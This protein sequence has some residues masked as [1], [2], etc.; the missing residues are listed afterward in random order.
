MTKQIIIL[1]ILFLSLWGSLYGQS[2]QPEKQE[3]EILKV[4]AEPDRGYQEFYAY[5]AKSLRY[6]PSAVERGIEGKVYVSF[7]IDA[8]GEIVDESI[9]IV[10]SPDESLNEETI[11]IIKECPAWTP[12]K[13]KAGENAKQ[14]VVL[15][16]TYKLDKG[17]KKK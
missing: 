12:G 7:I 11:R 13:N 9:A 10:Q 8:T 17:R 15:P 1:G 16:V 4:P 3:F 14:K 2:D 6:P 5:I